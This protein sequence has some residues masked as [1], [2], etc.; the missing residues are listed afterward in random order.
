MRISD[1]SSDVCSS[2]LIRRRWAALWSRCRAT[3]GHQLQPSAGQ[4]LFPHRRLGC[5]QDV[6]AQD[7]L[8][9]AAAEPRSE[10]RRV[11]KDGVRPVRSWWWPYPYIKNINE[12][13]QHCLNSKQAETTT[14]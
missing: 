3:L 8:S 1:W 11:G 4:L 9:R 12:C 5:G 10:A 2:D 6:A 14:H 13:N 7:A